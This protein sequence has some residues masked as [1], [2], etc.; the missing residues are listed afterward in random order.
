MSHALRPSGDEDE[1]VTTIGPVNVDW[2]R[3]FGYYA[4]VGAA[5]ALE[6]IA[7]PLGVFIALVPLVK[8]LKRRHAS[9]VERLMGGVVEGAGKPVGGDADGVVRLK[10]IDDRREQSETADAKPNGSLETVQSPA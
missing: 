6:V 2:P 3:A 7:P 9:R 5:V 10:W 8:L 4:A 1:F